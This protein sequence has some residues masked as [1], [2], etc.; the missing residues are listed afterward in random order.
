MASYLKTIERTK[1]KCTRLAT[2]MKDYAL[3]ETPG[4]KNS[5]SGFSD[6]LFQMEDR[7]KEMY[8]R[9]Q[10]KV[11]EGM[12]NY[13]TA[14]KDIK[15]SMKACSEAEQVQTKKQK[16]LAV[17]NAK[18]GA[19]ISKVTP[20]RQALAK[21]ASDTKAAKEKFHKELENFEKQKIRDFK[22]IWS[23]YIHTHIMYHSKALE[24]FTRAHLIINDVDEDEEMESILRITRARQA[25]DDQ[26]MEDEP[27]NSRPAT[28]ASP[29]SSRSP[30]ANLGRSAL[31]SSLS[32]SSPSLP[33]HNSYNSPPNHSYS[34]SSLPVHSPH[35]PAPI[36]RSTVSLS[37]DAP[38]P[39]EQRE[40]LRGMSTP[41]LAYNSQGGAVKRTA[42]SS[43]LRSSRNTV[44]SVED[45]EDFDD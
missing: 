4:L 10:I 26:Q 2:H 12:K 8:D 16:D 39:R 9:L 45:D 13:E 20:A 34:T 21:A 5:F 38:L 17:M 27:L 11:Y 43:S 6:C 36:R 37:S 33:R 22:A 30:T 42:T 41:Q 25:Q 19:D 1:I 7:R 44:P 24:I 32:S 40:I 29:S 14:C 31:N 35:S 18:K 28:P 23:E 3:V 15:E